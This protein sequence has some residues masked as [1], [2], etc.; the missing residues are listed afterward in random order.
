MTLDLRLGVNATTGTPLQTVT[1]STDGDYQFTNIAAGTYTIVAKASG[2]SDATKTGISVGGATT[3]NQDIFMSPLGLAG[4]VRVV[5]TWRPNPRDLDS[6]LSGPTSSGNRF[7]V[8]YGDTGDCTATPFACLDNDVTSG[9][10]PETI[11]I[12]QQLPGIYRYSVH[13][14]SGSPA[15]SQSGARVDLYINNALAQSF[16]VPAG[17][18]DYWTVFELNGTVIT[19]INTIGNSSNFARIPGGAG[20]SASRIPTSAAGPSAARNDN[21]RIQDANTRHPKRQA[22]PR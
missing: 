17:S 18:G 10:G 3:G 15:L 4:N 1:A 5:L 19:P 9:S 2:Y 11:T 20:I 14:Y 13:R 6:Y 12:T 16:A 21:A 8:W 7:L 22:T